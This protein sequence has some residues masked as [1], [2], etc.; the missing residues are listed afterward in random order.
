MK[1]L[2]DIAHPPAAW[3]AR[4]DGVKLQQYKSASFNGNGT[5]RQT[6]RKTKTER[7]TDGEKDLHLPLYH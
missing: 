2:L 5:E 4:N 6:E 7:K 1:D 3:R